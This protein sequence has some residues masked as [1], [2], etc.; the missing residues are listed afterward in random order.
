[1][2]KLLQKGWQV[3][4]ANSKLWMIVWLVVIFPAV[5]LY[6]FTQ[7]NNASQDNVHTLELRRIGTLHDLIE[8]MVKEGLPLH[9][10]LGRLNES[11]ADIE[12]LQIVTEF[13]S[14]LTVSY[15]LDQT[16]VGT[17]VET[18]APYRSA[19]IKPGETFIYEYE[20]GGR[21]VK[22]AF[23]ALPDNGTNTYIF[24]EH[25]FG[26][27][28]ALM[29]HRVTQ[30]YYALFFIFI[31]IIVLAYW[32]ANQINFQTLY[33]RTKETLKER[34]LFTNSLAH[35]LRAPLTAMRGYA[36][37]IVESEAVP[38]AEHEYAKKI[39]DSTLRLIHLVNDFLEA[40]RIQSGQLPVNRAVIDLAQLIKKVATQSELVA[41]EKG[42][43]LTTQ[44]PDTTTAVNTDS[45]RLEQILTNIISNSI[46][47]TKQGSVSI[48]LNQSK[49]KSIITI[50]DTGFGI[51]AEDQ[52]RIFAPFVRVGDSAQLAEITGT[53]L[54]MWITKQLIT[55][56]GGSIDIESIKGVGTH[57][58]IT[59]PNA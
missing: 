3:I 51:S 46:K 18:A 22:Q 33:T 55:Q 52:K 6:A 56:L 4:K 42:L 44:I 32:L 20:V 12:R 54:G 48:L 28:D 31:F 5:F 57:V 53:G 49:A 45:K 13:D 2:L 19:L 35:E 50:A 26:D 15:D 34:D 21:R 24:S 10:L 43:T 39:D 36:S 16:K 41:T 11:G 59:I 8:P 25:D 9:A 27:L 40:A 14:V 47:Y 1:M 37:L 23:R 17:T 30:S 58:I 29:E 38:A 7:L